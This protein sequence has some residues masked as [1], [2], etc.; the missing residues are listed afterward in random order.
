MPEG[1]APPRPSRKG[2]EACLQ[3]RGH[4]VVG[5]RDSD[6]VPRGQHPNVHLGS[7]GRGATLEFP[8]GRLV[9]GV[10]APHPERRVSAPV[11]GDQ[12]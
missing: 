11:D 4:R 8:A 2:E 10:S 1:R 6:R 5:H 3:R 9:G 12:V 7:D